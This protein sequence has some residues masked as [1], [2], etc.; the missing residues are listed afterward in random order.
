MKQLRFFIEHVDI[1]RWLKIRNVA[2]I[3]TDITDSVMKLSIGQTC[4]VLFTLLLRE[5]YFK[6]AVEVSAITGAVY[7]FYA[8]SVVIS[9][10]LA[11]ILKG[12]ELYNVFLITLKMII[13]LVI[14]GLTTS[15][16]ESLDNCSNLVLI[17]AL[18]L[19]LSKLTKKITEGLDD[20]I[21]RSLYDFSRVLDDFSILTENDV[22]NLDRTDKVIKII[23]QTRA[24]KIE[25]QDQSTNEISYHLS[26]IVFDYRGKSY[27]LRRLVYSRAYNKF[28]LIDSR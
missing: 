24:S 4:L 2:R 3:L 26:L 28:L 15:K 7:V 14:I 21:Q 20:L 11:L 10:L 22:L 13:S 12:S 8:A 25:N 9:A 18:I 19:I 5:A 23:R 27:D 16:I 1:I 6:E 17:F